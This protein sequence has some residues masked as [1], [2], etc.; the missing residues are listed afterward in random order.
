M[1][2]LPDLMSLAVMVEVGKIKLPLME[3]KRLQKRTG[4][5]LTALDNTNDSSGLL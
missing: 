5:V 1:V 3:K 4:Q 2:P